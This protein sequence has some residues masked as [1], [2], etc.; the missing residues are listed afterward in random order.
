MQ[1]AAALHINGYNRTCEGSNDLLGRAEGKF[2][3]HEVIGKHL[4]SSVA[5][6]YLSGNIEGVPSIIDPFCGDGRLIIWLIEALSDHKTLF[7]NG[8][9]IEVWDIDP[10]IVRQCIANIRSCLENK[11]ITAKILGKTGDSFDMTLE[12]E[13]CYDIV[14]T[15]PPWDVLKPDTR[16]IGN[17]PSNLVPDYIEGLR[18][19]SKKLLTNYP[20]S[21]PKIRFSGWGVNLARCGTEMALRL[22]KSGGIAGIVS[23]AS[24]MA[25]Q[26]S[27][28]LRQWLLD[29]HTIHDLAYFPAE[30]RLF[31]GVDQP[32]MTLVASRT[33]IDFSLPELTVFD[34]QPKKVSRITISLNTKQLCERDFIIPLQLNGEQYEIINHCR[35]FPSIHALEEKGTLWLGRELDETRYQTYVS[36]NGNHP[37]LKGR[38]IGR[39]SIVEIPKLHVCEDLQRIPESVTRTRLVWRD[40]ARPAQK[41]RMRA[42]LIPPGWV[43]GNSLNVAYIKNDNKNLLKA[44]LIIFNSLVFEFQIR[45]YLGTAHLSLGSIRKV[46]IPNLK[47]EYE[48]Y[49]L[50]QLADLIMKDPDHL[51]IEGEVAVAKLYGLDKAAFCSVLECYSKLSNYEKELLLDDSLWFGKKLTAMGTHS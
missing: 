45:A 12:K 37:F 42:T 43:T 34:K 18:S 8:C 21:C 36:T 14:V 1:H 22:L 19:T 47:D 31:R 6:V 27:R 17:L 29:N 2:Y 26:V 25:D 44:L 3:T 20:T 4:V 13:G 32:C 41:R 30:A 5:S 51:D 24:L 15:N 7:R 16:E 38:M 46:R 40:V 49:R 35:H 28:N 39:Y 23:P 33:K 9:Y 48:L 50:A 10:D 11:G